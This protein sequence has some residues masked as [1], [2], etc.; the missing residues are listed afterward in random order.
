MLLPW[1]L[2]RLLLNIVLWLL[3]MLPVV[4]AAD[5]FCQLVLLLLLVA[6][7]IVVGILNGCSVLLLICRFICFRLVAF[8]SLTSIEVESCVGLVLG[9]VSIALDMSKV[10][11]WNVGFLGF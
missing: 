6:T 7:E 8:F 4:V 10:W 9:I 2:Q 1:W 5:G 3:L 11:F